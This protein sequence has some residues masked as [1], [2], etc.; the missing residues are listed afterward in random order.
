[1]LSITGYDGRIVVR[2]I[3]D[4]RVSEAY[5]NWSIVGEQSI[6]IDLVLGTGG[7]QRLEEVS[8]I[9]F[10]VEVRYDDRFC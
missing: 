9:R 8:F 4:I 1:M 10:A 7:V 6:E 5:Q 2:K 3:I